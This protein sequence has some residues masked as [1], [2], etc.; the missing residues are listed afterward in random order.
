MH[1]MSVV[2][3][4]DV[5]AALSAVLV[6]C[7]VWYVHYQFSR[8]LNIPESGYVVDI[9]AGDSST[10]TIN[11]L[12]ANGVIEW[13]FLFRGYLKWSGRDRNIKAGE[14]LVSPGSTFDDLLEK[15]DRGDVILREVTLVEGWT[16]RQALRHLCAQ[17]EIICTLNGDVAALVQL[18]RTIASTDSPEGMLYPDTYRFSRGTTD[19]EIVTKANAKLL[20]VLEAEWKTRDRDT[21]LRSPY[22]ALILASIVEKE[23]SVPQERRKIAGVFS[24]RLLQGMRLQTDPTVIYG[25]GDA[26]AG[27]ITREH[28]QRYTPYNT[29]K[30]DGLPPTPIALAGVESI[31]AALHPEK[32]EEL[33]FVARGDGTHEFASSLEEHNRNV[34]KYQ[35]RARA[36]SAK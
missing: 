32:G 1:W 17:P 19:A 15:I 27:N 24:R 20:E 30:I 33:Y 34:Y 8:P 23:T 5:L 22:E 3:T 25:L 31:H 6:A 10:K 36:K 16:V 21:P 18:I 9:R 7:G 28:L 26:Y 11:D 12:A 14:Y 2:R 29:Y 4:R 13:P 35:I